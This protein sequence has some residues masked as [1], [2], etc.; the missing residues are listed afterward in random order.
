MEAESAASSSPDF[1]TRLGCRI[2]AAAPSP[3]T[4][5]LGSAAWGLSMAFAAAAGLYFSHALIV[6]QSLAIVSLLFYGPA[7]GF[8]PGL[9]LAELICGKAGRKT[10]FV[11]GTVILALA[12]HTATAAIFALQYRVFYA[13]WQA[14]FPSVVW[15]FQFAFTTASALYQFTIDS[16]YVYF[17]LAPLLL[18]LLGIWFAR[19]TH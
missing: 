19:R 1:F 11:V 6:I 4:V 10:R 12:T 14:D 7:A 2:Y 15:C 16:R 13:H 3:V 9:W 5:L 8:A 17:P 18:V